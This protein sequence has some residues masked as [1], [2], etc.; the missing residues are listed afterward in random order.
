MV[1]VKREKH[2]TDEKMIRRFIKKVKK[3]GI[4]EEFL[5]KR[6]YIKPSDQKRIDKK[7]LIAEHK[8]RLAKEN[9]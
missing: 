8:K 4:I 5:S 2:D 1:A 3:F 7:R 6:F 9:R